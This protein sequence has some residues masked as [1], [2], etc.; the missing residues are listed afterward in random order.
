MAWDETDD[1]TYDV[2]DDTEDTGAP[3]PP[4]DQ[5][6]D[7]DTGPLVPQPIAARAQQPLINDTWRYPATVNPDAQTEPPDDDWE[8]YRPE[9]PPSAPKAAQPPD[10]DWE[11]YKPATAATGDDWEPYDPSATPT[12]PA[13]PA[14]EPESGIGTLT[15]ELAHGLGPSAAAAVGGSLTAGA[16]GSVAGPMGAFGAG[17]VGGGLAAYGASVAQEEGLKALGHD[18]A[19]QRAINVKENPWWAAAGSGVSNLAGFGAGVGR[20]AVALAADCCPVPSAAVA[21]RRVQAYQGRS[22]TEAIPPVVAS[23]AAGLAFPQPRSVAVAAGEAGERLGTSIKG[24]TSGPRLRPMVPLARKVRQARPRR[25]PRCGRPRAS[26][27]IPRTRRRGA[28][29]TIQWKALAHR[30]R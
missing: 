5:P 8:P 18:D 13:K 1:D 26:S 28:S 21:K 6:D 9:A 24:N 7:A 2:A 23:T 30:G 29:A 3:P 15:R 17:L 19:A 10:D 14:V 16:A 20:G 27:A 11:A 25:S 22:R 4:P 12:A